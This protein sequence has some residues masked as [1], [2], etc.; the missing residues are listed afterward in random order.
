M[1]EV[2]LRIIE[3]YLPDRRIKQSGGSNVITTCP[4]HKGGQERKPSFSIN[5]DEGLFHCFTCHEAGDI[6]KMLQMLGVPETRIE[7]ETSVIGPALEQN[8]QLQKLR[9]TNFHVDKDPF[10]AEFILPESLLGVYDWMPT[11][12]VEKGFD[13]SLLREM[14]IGFDR[15]TDRITYPIRDMYG[16][17]AGISGGTI[18][19]GT[20]P[21]YKVYEGQRRGSDGQWK[22]SDFGVGFDEM[23]PTYRMENH[24]YL[25]NFH[26]VW[27]R[28]SQMSDGSGTLYIV[29][30]FKACL[31]MIQHGY[32]N[33]VAIM[34]TSLSENQQRMIHR[35]GCTV[36]LCLDNDA[37]GRR[38]TLR[39]GRQLM[40]PMHGR[41]KT[42]YYPPVD[43]DGQPDDYP[44]G[45]L[46]YVV[47]H[48]SSPFTEH[49]KRQARQS[50]R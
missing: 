29:E 18:V 42:A 27:P 13:V 14:N 24:N 5:L 2:V 43:E 4:F 31:W 15:K 50:Q 30:G 20:F 48:M 26:Q 8:R 19:P 10:K 40:G 37:P 41:V 46:H 16:N 21:K 25:W 32:P 38:A 34:G 39:I 11:S 9:K 45:Q 49:L 7:L 22:H 12:L 6:K 44:P 1:R 3:R 23:F 36:V 47:N 17:L 35:L 28:L 33:T